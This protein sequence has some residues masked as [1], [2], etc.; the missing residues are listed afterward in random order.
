MRKFLLSLS[1]MFLLTS[2]SN[3]GSNEFKDSTKAAFTAAVD[4]SFSAATYKR[5]ISVAV[6]KN[7]LHT[8]T[9]SS[10]YADGTIGTAVGT[11]MTDSTPTYAYS[12]TKTFVSALI[13]TQIENGLYSLNDTVEN[14]L[15]SHAD[16]SSF[17]FSRINKNATVAQLLK[18][19]SGMPD[20]ASNVAGL[21]PMCDPAASWKP[22]DIIT[23]IVNANFSTSNWTNGVFEYSNTNYVLLG[24]I[25]E[26]KGG[27]NL[28]TLL[29]T[30]FF[31]KI[32]I[33]AELAP[34]DSVPSYIAHPYDDAVLFGD[35]TTPPLGSFTDFSLAILGINATYNYYTG[36][37]RGTWAAGGIIATAEN[38][39]IWGYELYDEYGAAVTSEVRD[40]IKNSADDDGD[41]GYGVSY[42]D[43][44]YNDGTE[45][46]KYG[47]GGSAPGYKTLLRYETREGLS[48][49][50]ITNVNN[51][52][53]TTG[54]D[55]GAGIVDREALADAIFN[56]YKENQY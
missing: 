37:G 8:W 12:I 3:D 45:G 20:Y 5:G 41:Y 51:S 21:I 28:N 31:S 44:T 53:D 18:H 1:I 47:H 13:L 32:G 26:H 27:K 46:S 29:S 10:G 50:I 16:Y 33:D 17:N 48:V 52:A 14:L 40:T 4:S 42:N 23:G 56:A 34:Q 2:C 11:A 36:V 9:Y 49:A 38:L 35:G 19:T 24:M 30:A 39:A 43:F 15:S 7:G 22:A 54:T 6:Y 55:S 25:A